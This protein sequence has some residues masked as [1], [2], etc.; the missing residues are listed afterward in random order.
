MISDYLIITGI[1][2]LLAWSVYI[3]LLTGSLSFAQGAFM[4]IGCYAA[5]YLTTELGMPFWPATLISAVVTAVI[6]GIIG[7]PALRLRGIYL[8]L[9]TLGITFCVRV[10]LE[11]LD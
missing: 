4:A 3:V 11:N 7:F 5:S 6:A 1:N 2:V 10:L 8:I 9:G